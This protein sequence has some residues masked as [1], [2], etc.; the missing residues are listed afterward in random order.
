MSRS[1]I[2]FWMYESRGGIPSD[3]D[4]K[5]LKPILEQNQ[6]EKQQKVFKVNCLSPTGEIKENPQVWLHMC[7]VGFL[8]FNLPEVS[9]D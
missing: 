6:Q 3:F 9:D 5:I 2:S 8:W 4:D 7:T 1:E